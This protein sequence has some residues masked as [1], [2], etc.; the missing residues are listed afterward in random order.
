VPS[1]FPASAT[2]VNGQANVTV[3]FAKAGYYRIEASGPSGSTGWVTV[4]V[5]VTPNT[6]P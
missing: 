3:K 2:L 5:G 1:S 6:A 4:D